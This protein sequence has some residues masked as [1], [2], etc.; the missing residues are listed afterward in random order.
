[1]GAENAG[2]NISFLLTVMNSNNTL[3]KNIRAARRRV[4]KGLSRK[5]LAVRLKAA[6][7]DFSD[8]DVARI[9]AGTLTL[10]YYQVTVMASEL[11]TT[12]HSLHTDLPA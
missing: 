3:G 11:E 8:R 4:G 12:V 10:N 1:M 5:D 2:H 7:L 6:G 9:E